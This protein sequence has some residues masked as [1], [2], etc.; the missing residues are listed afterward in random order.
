MI[1][2]GTFSSLR[3][4]N[5]RC[6]FAG[7]VLRGAGT[8]IQQ[9]TTG[10][11]VYD[12]TGSAVL[13]GALS[14]FRTLPYLISGPIAGV[15]ADRMDRR[16]LMVGI[17]CLFATTAL[18]MGIIV[19]FELVRVWH[20]FIFALG[21]GIAGSFLQTTEHSLVPTAVPRDELM[22]AVA[23]QYG[24]FHVTRII[25]P[26][27]GGLLIPMFGAGS[28]FFVQCAFIASAAAM[29]YSLRLPPM[30]GPTRDVSLLAHF[31]EGLA[32]VLSNRMVLALMILATIPAIFALPYQ[33]LMPIFQKD[34]FRVGPEGLG[35]MMAAPGLGAVLAMLLLASIAKAIRRKG[36]LLLVSL[37]MIGLCLIFF[38][39]STTLPLALL[40]LLGM[41][42]FHT[43][44]GATRNAMVQL[45][46]PDKLRG[47]VNSLFL[48]E[49]GV[50]PAGAMMAGVAAHLFGAPLAV[51]AMGSI[52][53][54]FALLVLWQVPRFRGIST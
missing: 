51:T 53:T 13:L 6:I 2:L 21:T 39:R 46:V 37:M 1:R 29:T 18:V 32:Y 43:L 26:V 22:N 49:R 52:V 36:M 3:H 17:Y 47:R 5:F 9:L 20:L 19:A 45:T 16:K 8:I 42:A 48:I 40:V 11:L 38:S 33:G 31:K 41:G 12:L 28:N 35:L 4:N 7:T 15:A 44:F 50:T 23:L 14:G 34:V 54:F 27:L 10:W 30:E 24:G 25:A